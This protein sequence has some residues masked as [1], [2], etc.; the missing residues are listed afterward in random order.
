MKYRSVYPKFHGSRREKVDAPCLSTLQFLREQIYPGQP[1]MGTGHQPSP[2]V[3]N[4]LSAEADV[5]LA[6]AGVANFWK[7]P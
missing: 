1:T 3:G 4:P 5:E 7:Y 2:K 6:H